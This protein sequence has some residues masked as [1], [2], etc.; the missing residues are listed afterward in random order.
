MNGNSGRGE[1]NSDGEFELGERDKDFFGLKSGVGD[2]GEDCV[3]PLFDGLR[4]RVPRDLSV[5]FK[6][7]ARS[8]A[9]NTEFWTGN[10]D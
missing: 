2:D 1:T 5:M 7:G 8:D 3:S 6:K 9:L 10:S 4:A